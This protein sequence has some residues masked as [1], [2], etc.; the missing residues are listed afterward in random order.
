MPSMNPS[1]VSFARRQFHRA[2][3]RQSH[4]QFSTIE[5]CCAVCDGRDTSTPIG[6]M[7]GTC[8]KSGAPILA[9]SYI[10]KRMPLRVKP[11]IGCI[12]YAFSKQGKLLVVGESAVGRHMFKPIDE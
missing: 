6:D 9:E 1:C 5:D 8:A 3:R 2:R 11:T 4:L 12:A 7:R 10:E